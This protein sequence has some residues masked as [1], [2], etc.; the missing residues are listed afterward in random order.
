MPANIYEVV[1]GVFY[2]TLRDFWYID[3]Q[4]KVC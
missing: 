2:V 3:K 4:Y 1:A